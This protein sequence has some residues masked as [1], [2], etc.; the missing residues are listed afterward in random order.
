MS[1]YQ[2]LKETIGQLEFEIES[3][4]NLDAEIDRICDNLKEASP[5]EVDEALDFS[6]YYGTLW[7]AARALSMKLWSLR[8]F[9]P[10]RKLIEV[11]CGLA[12]PSFVASRLGADVVATDFHPEVSELMKRNVQRNL[13]L[14]SGLHAFRYEELNLKGS[15]NSHFVQ[16]GYDWVVGSDILY[17]QKQI[18]SVV[19]SM[20]SLAGT[21]GRILLA[22]PGRSYL[23]QAIQAFRSKN[24]YDEMNTYHFAEK[25]IY[26]I[27]FQYLGNDWQ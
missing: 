21:R 3:F 15:L 11:G 4:S 18:E 9:L 27:E 8:E 12:L 17:E 22:D 13:D 23:K 14:K 24:W 10:G 26:V 7:P 2:V 16:G 6:P 1:R 5:S 19:E 25:E 20:T